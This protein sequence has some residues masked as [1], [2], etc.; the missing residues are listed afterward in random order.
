MGLKKYEYIDSLRGIAILLVIFVH[1]GSVLDNM[2]PYFSDRS[3]LVQMIYN[4]QYGVQMFFIVSAFTLMMS[5]YNRI[6]EQHRTRNFFIR[7]IFRIVPMYYAAIIYFTIYKYLDISLS[8][9]DFSAVPYKAL[10]YNLFF[11]NAFMPNHVNGYVPGGWSVSVEFIFYLFVPL[12]CSKIKNVNSALIFTL[13]TLLIPV[14]LGDLLGRIFYSYIFFCQ[15]PIFGL[16]I[17]AYMFLNRSGETLKPVT[18]I[19]LAAVV[20]IFCYTDIPIDFMHGIGFIIILIT[21]SRY[22]LK[23][24]SNRV[25]AAIGKVSFS[26]YLV[27]FAIIYIFNDLRFYNIIPVN[28]F[29]TSLIN[30]LLMYLLLVFLTFIVSKLTYTLIEI[31]GQ[32]LGRKLIKKLDQQK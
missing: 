6:D 9:I 22:N 25:L 5:Y 15:L 18:L 2:M 21:Q 24:L 16:G 12:I 26:M 4:G 1:T 14:F 20:F 3:I 13:I 29:G 30:F 7:R 8:H 31:P 19:L 11:V 17:F 27:H 23:V 28:S 32:N 10:L